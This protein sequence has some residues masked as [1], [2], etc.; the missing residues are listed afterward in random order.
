M[1][2]YKVSNDIRVLMQ[3]EFF[4]GIKVTINDNLNKKWNTRTIKFNVSKGKVI[5]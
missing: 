1:T 2:K 4:L 5:Y 3:L